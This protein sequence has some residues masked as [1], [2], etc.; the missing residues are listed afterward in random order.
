MALGCRQS[1]GRPVPRTPQPRA[2][3]RLYKSTVI[4]GHLHLENVTLYS[5]RGCDLQNPAF[6]QDRSPFVAS[7]TRQVIRGGCRNAQSPCFLNSSIHLRSRYLDWGHQAHLW[8]A[9]GVE[10]LGRVSSNWRPRATSGCKWF[11]ERNF[12]TRRL[13]TRAG[14]SRPEPTPFVETLWRRSGTGPRPGIT[15]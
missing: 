9:A 12:P 14:W 7:V 3:L 6:V 5:E 13:S 11:S 8:I 10:L 1:A 4:Q 2:C 15:L